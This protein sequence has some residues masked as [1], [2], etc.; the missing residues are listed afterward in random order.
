MSDLKYRISG[1]KDFM[2]PI[3]EPKNLDNGSASKLP[4]WM[5]KI[6]DF[7]EST[8]TGYQKYCELFGW[9]GESSR[10]IKNDIAG[11][12]TPTATLRHSEVVIV[13]P[14]FAF[15]AELENMMNAGTPVPEIEIVNIDSKLGK[16]QSIQFLGC[17][18]T[19]IQQEL[20]R[21]VV[22]MNILAKVDT[23]KV[24]SVLGIPA[25][26][27]VSRVDYMTGIVGG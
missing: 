4:E 21:V 23:I 7:C 25:G 11:F 3:V 26:Q 27:K 1:N 24:Y 16:K 5:V 19:S 17:T 2:I 22:K 9:Y 6:G 15:L 13:I 14:V 8:I 10:K 18:L 20:D 12:L